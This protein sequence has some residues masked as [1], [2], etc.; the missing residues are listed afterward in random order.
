M[1]NCELNNMDKFCLKW[2]EFETNIRE[3]FR[4]LRGEGRLFDITLATDDGQH[5][6]AHKSILSAGSHFF[7]D[8]FMKSNHTNMLI[9]LKGISY[10]EVKHVIDF[11]YDGEVLVAQDDITKVL[12]AAQELKLKGLQ[13][14]LDGIGKDDSETKQSGF[15]ECILNEKQ[16]KNKKIVDETSLESLGENTGTVSTSLEPLEEN[17]GTCAAVDTDLVINDKN[18]VEKKM[19]HEIDLQIEQMIEKNG[20]MQTC[21]E[22]GKTTSQKINLKRHVETHIKGFSHI[23]QICNKTFSNR[24]GL[25]VHMSGIH[26]ALIACEVCGKTGMNKTSFRN[27]KH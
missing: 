23:C 12:E 6:Q 5:M 20:V 19:N 27:H 8:I 18:N 9:Y 15:Q 3:S 2:G 4:T 16:S 24:P 22:C 13:G 14:Y 25:Q 10:V 7:S 1:D 21:K 17:T 11:I 26:S